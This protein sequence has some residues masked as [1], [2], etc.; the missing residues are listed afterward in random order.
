MP[1]WSGALDPPGSNRGC[2]AGQRSPA[3]PDDAVHFFANEQ[4]ALK[5]MAVLPKRF[6][7]FGLTLHPEKTR[8]V[9]FRRPD[10][11]GPPLGGGPPRRPG[12]FDLLGFTHFWGKS[13]AGKWTVKRSTASFR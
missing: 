7:K 2:R 6:G 1:E 11:R 8:L 10:K 12:T 9:E 3:T 13:R 5:V 4:D